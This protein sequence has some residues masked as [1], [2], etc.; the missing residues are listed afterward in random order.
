MKLYRFFIFALVFVFTSGFIA[1]GEDLYKENSD[2]DEEEISSVTDAYLSSQI[3]YEDFDS[4]GDID[5]IV[6][7][8]FDSNGNVTQSIYDETD[9]DEIN[10][11][12]TYDYDSRNNVVEYTIDGS[13]DGVIDATVTYSYSYDSSNRITKITEYA[14][15][16]LYSE[17]TRSYGYD[18]ARGMYY[19]LFTS[20]DEDDEI[21][22]VSIGY[23]DEE[24]E[25]FK[26][27]ETAYLL[28]ANSFSYMT[29][30]FDSYGNYVSTTLQ[31]VSN[32]GELNDEALT[33]FIEAFEEGSY[34]DEIYY[35]LT[36]TY[37]IQYDSY[38]NKLS[39]I[40]EVSEVG[41]MHAFYV[42]EYSDGSISSLDD[43]DEDHYPESFDCDDT[44]SKVTF[45]EGGECD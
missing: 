39:E 17:E 34:D 35:S 36:T 11:V 23:Y 14:D 31:Q 30:Q 25:K 12:S 4:D 27:W 18:D 38:E 44:S 3:I 7:N 32:E 16:E 28:T 45:Q 1:C 20:Y 5:A 9:D 24:I 21:T 26:K 43:N 2:V 10:S 19:I 42:N 13:N 37:T 8:T 40:T 22:D 29:N 41:P 15:G 6:T 33:Q